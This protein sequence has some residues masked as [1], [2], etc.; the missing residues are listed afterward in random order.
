MASEVLF[1]AS[2]EEAATMY[3]DGAG[4]TVVAGGTILLP[5]IASGRVKP[6]R[7]LMLHRCG[8]DDIRVEDG[9]VRIGAMVP[10]AQL[11][12]GPEPLL[13]RYAEHLADYEVRQNATVGGNV[14]APAGRES[15]LGD[16]GAALIALGARVRSTGRGGERTE[17]IED[18]LSGDRSGRLVLELELD[19]VERKIGATGL[20]RRHAH[21]YAI[22][23]V[24]ACE[25]N[26]ELRV[27]VAGIGPTAVRCRSVEQSRDAADVLKDVE[28]VDDAV[29]S[30]EY[31]RRVLPLLVREALDQLENA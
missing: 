9:A 14:C 18:F 22:A 29:A 2:A 6:E 8:L 1:P 13:S 21:S 20:R 16:L 24:A 19:R 15:Q 17:P 28:P 5:E 4:I 31:R 11:V 27:A 10:I 7:A 30:A 26:G 3:G 25:A 23:N 12:D